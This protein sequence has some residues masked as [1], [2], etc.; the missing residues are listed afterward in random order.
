MSASLV[1]AFLKQVHILMYAATELSLVFIAR[2]SCAKI[3]RQ[4]WWSQHARSL[5]FP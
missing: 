1:S 3:L 5:I 2:T 4:I